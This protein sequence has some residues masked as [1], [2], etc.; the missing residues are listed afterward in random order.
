M[1]PLDSNQIVKLSS[2]FWTL[3]SAQHSCHI[4]SHEPERLEKISLDWAI[5]CSTGDEQETAVSWA[6]PLPSDEWHMHHAAAVTPG[7]QPCWWVRDATV[8]RRPPM[9]TC[10]TQ[11]LDLWRLDFTVGQKLESSSRIIWHVRLFIVKW[12]LN[13]WF[14]TTSSWSK[15]TS[16]VVNIES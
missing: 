9:P 8:L 5:V 15:S 4:W 7:S 12:S 13:W 11:W 1:R 2:T 14:C 16:V 10:V 3:L 6:L